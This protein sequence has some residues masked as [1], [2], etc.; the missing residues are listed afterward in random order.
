MLARTH[1]HTFMVEQGRHVMGMSAIDDEG[2]DRNARLRIAKQTQARNGHELLQ[3][4]IAKFGFN[5][6]DAFDTDIFDPI[7]GGAL[8]NESSIIGDPHLE[9]M[10]RLSLYP[11]LR[12]HCFAFMQIRY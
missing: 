9:A 7:D 1:G 6:P 2:I 4:A 8:P 12:K 3:G 10:R 11:K 5:R